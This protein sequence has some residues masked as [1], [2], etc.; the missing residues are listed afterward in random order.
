[1]TIKK[2]LYIYSHYNKEGDCFIKVG[3]AVDQTP[4]ERLKQHQTSCG[5]MEVL[6]IIDT[7]NSTLQVPQI[8]KKKLKH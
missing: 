6:A 8:Q 2:G 4:E 5:G 1:M 3:M 7:T